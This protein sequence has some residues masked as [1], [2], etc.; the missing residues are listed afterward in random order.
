MSAGSSTKPGGYAAFGE[1]PLGQFELED[2]RS[3]AEVAAAI[4]GAGYDPVWKDFDRAFDA[5]ADS[6]VGVAVAQ[7]G[8]LIANRK[9]EISDLRS[10]I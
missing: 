5:V 7:E 9:S 6:S 4:K 2:L 8:D 1:V 10:Q 3:P